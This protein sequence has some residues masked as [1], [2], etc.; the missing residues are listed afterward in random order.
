MSCEYSII[1]ILVVCII[2]LDFDVR[3]L[4]HYSFGFDVMGILTSHIFAY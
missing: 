2:S 1:M 4:D 3:T